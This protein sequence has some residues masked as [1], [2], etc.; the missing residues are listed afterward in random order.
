MEEH[1]GLR[2]VFFERGVL[3]GEEAAAPSM[4]IG[5]LELQVM[6]KRFYTIFMPL[7]PTGGSATM[8]SQTAASTMAASQD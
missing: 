3:V 2:S 7:R 8:S 4:K 5:P 1:W 6:E